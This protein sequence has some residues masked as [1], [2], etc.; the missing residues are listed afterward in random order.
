MAHA[1]RR[2]LTPRLQKYVEQI[3]RLA[4]MCQCDLSGGAAADLEALVSMRVSHMHPHVVCTPYTAAVLL[5]SAS[6]S[7]V[8]PAFVI[9]GC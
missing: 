4:D 1:L 3:S 6:S 9:G 7:M 2:M 8:C 5:L